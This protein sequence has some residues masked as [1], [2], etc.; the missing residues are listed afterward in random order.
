[1]TPLIASASL[2]SEAAAL[3][4]LCRVMNVIPCS[5]VPHARRR[6][7]AVPLGERLCAAYEFFRESVPY[8][9]VTFEQ[10]VF[11]VFALAEGE[12]CSLDRCRNCGSV[13]LIDHLRIVRRVCFPCQK[14]GREPKVVVSAG[15]EP[16]GP[17][18]E[19]VLEPV[20]FQRR[21]FE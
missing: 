12:L 21:L 4:G 19:E 9:R 15:E 11:L 7:P 17:N 14:A 2:M 8:A 18:P 3:A 1:L 20:G 13:I 6:L 16:A 10:T 5:P